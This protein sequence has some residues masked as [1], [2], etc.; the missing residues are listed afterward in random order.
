MLGS[1][2][3]EAYSCVWDFKTGQFSINGQSASTLSR[4]G[5]IKCQPVL[6]Q[7]CQEIPPR[8]QQAVT[9]R[10]TLQYAPCL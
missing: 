1:D 6:V 7:E 8:S 10:V 4:C 5:Y 2:W 9:A 3:L